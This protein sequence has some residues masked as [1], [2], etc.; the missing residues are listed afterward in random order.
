MLAVQYM[1]LAIEN[2]ILDIVLVTDEI[3]T[4][5]QGGIRQFPR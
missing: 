5:A 3:R 2:M 4:R 1:I